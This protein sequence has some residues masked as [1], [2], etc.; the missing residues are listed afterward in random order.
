M[1]GSDHDGERANAA[2]MANNLLRSKGLTWD[3][4][5]TSGASI[6]LVQAFEFST[7]PGYEPTNRP[8]YDPFAKRNDSFHWDN[9]YWAI[10]DAALANMERLTPWEQSFIRTLPSRR[11]L[12]LSAKQKTVLDGIEAK[13]NK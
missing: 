10:V 2:K 3:E 5:L 11:G 9:K 8:G 7:R 1:F 12:P 13:L 4:V 6:D